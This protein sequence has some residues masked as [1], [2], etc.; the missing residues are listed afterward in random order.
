MENGCTSDQRVTTMVG[1]WM[2]RWPVE[3][4]WR[5]GD[6]RMAYMRQKPVVVDCEQWLEDGDVD[7]RG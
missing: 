7:A 6:S 5:N 4:Q 3:R 2:H 1:E